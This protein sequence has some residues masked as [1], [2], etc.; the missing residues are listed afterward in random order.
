MNQEGNSQ[1]HPFEQEL[2]DIFLE[3]AG[4][5]LLQLEEDLLLLEQ[6]P[7]NTETI[8]SV[9]RSV[10]TIKG[11]AGLTGLNSIS[12]FA[13]VLE[14]MLDRIRKGIGKVPESHMMVLLDSLDL[15]RRMVNALQEGGFEDLVTRAEEIK[16]L[17][18]F[19]MDV[20]GER[21]D[22]DDGSRVRQLK[23][24]LNFK[25]DIFATGTD[26]LLLI[27][28]LKERGTII[29][30]NV[31]IAKLPP[32]S[33]FDPHKLYIRWVV[34]FETE[35]KVDEIREIFIFVDEQV[36]IEEMEYKVD[37]E[38]MAE[39][40]MDEL[41]VEEGLVDAEEIEDAVKQKRTV[42]DVL[43]ETGKVASSQAES[44]AKQK[45]KARETQEVRTIRVETKK[46]EDILDLVASLAIAQSRIKEIIFKQSDRFDSE[47]E[48]SFVFDEVDKIT[49]NL[50]EEVM[51]ASMVPIGGT[52]VRF[53]RMVRDLSKERG[54][55]IE[56]VISGKD[57]ELDRKVIEQITD[58][59]KHMIRNSIDHGV[60]EPEERERIG[61]PRKGSIYLKAY[62][63]EGGITIEVADDGRGFDSEAILEKARE[64]GLIQEDEKLTR[65]QI[66]RLPFQPG[67]STAKE[68]SDISGRGVGLDV[69]QTNIQALRGDIEMES[70]PQ[71][72][73]KFTIQLPLTLA[74][75][76]AMMI[77]VEEERFLLPITSIVEFVQM[78]EHSAKRVSGKAPVIMVRGEYIPLIS[79]SQTLGIEQQNGSLE[80]EMV[81]V[82]Q[83]QRRRI[84]LQVDEIIGQQQVVI[85]SIKENYDQVQGVAGATILGDG[86]VAMILDVT[87][88]VR[89]SLRR[90]Y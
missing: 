52:F 47:D 64:K 37:L 8:N 78:S 74:I 72:G 54:K 24:Y 69:V 40:E 22:E 56:L 42:E 68:V 15:L 83:D 34:F 57:T 23:I 58:P 30:T 13:H 79:L 44:I 62:H 48:I 66:F 9:F 55:D 39:K 25:P 31:N 65:E 82:V 5:I 26:P 6:E 59:L 21:Q 10:H 35:A 67:F 45:E 20:S 87:A 70:E 27:E 49:R 84:A 17:L 3:E 77:G 53:Q 2:V 36:Q 63:K 85:K 51:G 71:I 19:I 33:Q 29:R 18:T 61:K 41:L 60:E 4:E 46:L 90:S 50:Q 11:S 88:L 28:E 81:V 14:D 7:E 38:D 12:N 32:L 80:K 76:D 43:V 16:E 89:M 75:I 73:T 86:R 1:D